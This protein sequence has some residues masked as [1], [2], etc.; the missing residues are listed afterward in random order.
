MFAASISGQLAIGWIVGTFVS[1]A[2]LAASYMFDLPTGAAMV[3]AFGISLALAGMLYPF[4][5]GDRPQAIRM[6]ITAARWT[7][8]TILAAS[9]LQLAG[10]P[11]ADQPLLDIAEQAVPSL[12]R[13]YFTRA[14]ATTFADASEYAERYRREA[15][16]LNE[17]ARARAIAA[18]AGT[19]RCI[20]NHLRAFTTCVRRAACWRCME[21]MFPRAYCTRRNRSMFTSTIRKNGK[22]LWSRQAQ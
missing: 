1:A 5:R 17:R 2:G 16:Q 7:G 18:C 13:I 4:L 19:A 22:R 3:C 14:E 9:A 8:A 11:R 15:E 20:S 6:T 21:R 12:R 10:A